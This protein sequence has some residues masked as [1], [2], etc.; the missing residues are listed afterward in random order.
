[1]AILFATM[2]AFAQSKTKYEYDEM[3]RL[4]K[5]IYANGVTVD[6]TYDKLGN[7]QAKKVTSSVTPVA[8]DVN[9]DGM[10]DDDD[11]T[12]LVDHVV[13]RQHQEPISETAADMNTDGVVDIID[14]AKYIEALLK[15]A[16]ST[17][18]RGSK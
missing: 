13:G 4:T 16:R 5:V 17:E 15:N 18:S 10:V 9:N 14:I 1:M 12:S 8:G 3:Y 11:V 7:R 2:Q 6:Y